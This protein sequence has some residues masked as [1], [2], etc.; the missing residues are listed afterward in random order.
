M[1]ALKKDDINGILDK[2]LKASERCLT[3][4]QRGH[5]V[6]VIE[7]C[8]LPLYLKLSFDEALRWH[9]YDSVDVTSLHHTVEAMINALFERVEKTHGQL[10]VS[11]AL[12]YLTVGMGHTS[13]IALS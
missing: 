11:R 9:S 4:T 6:K 1:S 13:N 3:M 5:V 7:H 12:S 10:M 2:W 8:P